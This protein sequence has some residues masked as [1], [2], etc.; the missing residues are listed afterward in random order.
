M[1]S[2]TVFRSARAILG[3]SLVAD[4][5][6]DAPAMLWCDITA[7]LLHRSPLDGAADGSDDGVIALPAPVASFHLA[8]LDGA[9]GYVVSLGDRVVLV[10]A[11]G[12]IVRQ[13]AAIDHAHDGLRL[14][15]GKVDP[16]GRWVT[17][18]MDLTRGEPDGAFYSV[19]AE[20]ARVIA[21][22]IGTANGLEWSPDGTRIYYTDTSTQTIYTGAYSADGDI[23][24]VEV[25]HTG[26]MHDGLAMDAEGCLWGAVYGGGVVVRY[27]G[28][29]TELERHEFPAPNL[30]SVAFGGGDSATLYVA[31]ARENLTEGQLQRHP[32]SGS[33]FAL[34]T[35][36]SGRAAR[37]FV[38][39]G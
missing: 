23:S 2:P 34:Q 35:G 4:A 3:E 17:G 16:A 31:S 18:S 26:E 15:E 1:P 5:A 37:V 11:A 19:T 10:D 36:T 28:A 39:R 6:S 25:F 33:V 20:G 9:R 38:S 29:G 27:D 8:D 7:G 12:D 21:G 13:L 14:N 22:G 24:G 30:T 32:L